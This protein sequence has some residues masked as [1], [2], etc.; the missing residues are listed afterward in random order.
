MHALGPWHGVSHIAVAVSGGADSLSLA[1]LAKQWAT[2]EQKNLTALIVD[3]GLRDASA[4]EAAQAKAWL[5]QHNIAAHIIS[6]HLAG[7]TSAIQE[8]AR[9]A[10]YDAIHNWCNAHH[11]SHLLLGH[12]LGDQAETFLFRLLRGSGFNGLAA[13]SMKSDYQGLVLLRPLLYTPKRQL[14]NYLQSHH[15]SWIEDPSNQNDDFTRIQMRRFIER[16]H[17]AEALAALA[18]QFGQYRAREDARLNRLMQRYTL[19]NAHN[20]WIDAEFLSL[21]PLDQLFLLT[22]LLM[23]ISHRRDIPRSEKVTALLQRMQ[24]GDASSLHHCQIAPYKLNKRAGWQISPE[25]KEEQPTQQHSKNTA[26]T[27]KPLGIAP[28]FVMNSGINQ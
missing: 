16:H 9:T 3:H 12:H 8:T 7:I 26:L 13:M 14:T 2:A 24:Q 23:H 17:A 10:R 4:Q 27:A 1:L 18:Q 22:Q 5:G 25:L 15:Q 19:I 20:G 11:V 21:H 28:F 6:L